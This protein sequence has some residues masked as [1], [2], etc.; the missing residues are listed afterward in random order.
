M[1]TTKTKSYINNQS[2]GFNSV[3]KRLQSWKEVP[4]DTALLSL[5]HLHAYYRNEWQRGLAVTSCVY[6]HHELLHA[7]NSLF[8]SRE[9]RLKDEFLAA[10]ISPDEIEIMENISLEEIV[11]RVNEGTD[12]HEYTEPMKILITV[13]V[14]I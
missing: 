14:T 13:S 10:N 9:H 12:L 6:A 4:I 11:K 5:Y 2:E 1:Y 8:R 3:L 7:F